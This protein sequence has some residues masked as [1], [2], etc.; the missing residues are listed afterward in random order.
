MSRVLSPIGPGMLRPP[1]AGGGRVAD[2]AG[3]S[4]RRDEGCGG[5]QLDNTFTIPGSPSQT[6][7]DQV[8]TDFPA[9]GGTSAQLVFAARGGTTVNSP[10]NAAAISQVLTK[11]AAAPQVAAVVPPQQSHLVTK[12]GKTAIATV[13]YQVSASGLDSGTLPALTSIASAADS[14]TLSVEP[15][16]QAFSSLS[17]GSG[18]SE[19]TGLLIAFAVLAVALA[20]LVA[21]GMPLL[22]ALTG[23][24]VSVL[25]LYGLAAALS[26]SNTAVTLAVMIGL[27]V[28]VDYAL[29]IVSRHR[30][31]LAAGLSRRNRR[32]LRPARPAPLWCSRAVR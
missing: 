21:A 7:L 20:S 3:R 24:A 2:G 8:Q 16:G 18:S 32:P 6:A 28:G 29:F 12:D 22:T 14:N 27:A 25:T 1:V 19:V 13:Q 23:V 31:Q 10:A 4:G 17:S 30:A 9:A 15:G 5:G 11:A 26:V